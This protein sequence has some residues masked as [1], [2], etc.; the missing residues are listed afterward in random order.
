M[1]DYD[2]HGDLDIYLANFGSANR[3]FRNNGDSTF[4]DIGSSAGVADTGDGAGVAFGDYD[5]D[6]DLDLYLAN[7]GQANALF[8]NALNPY[9]NTFFAVKALSATNKWTQSGVR[10][11]LKTTI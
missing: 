3:L 2:A 8:V 10:V 6:G 7:Y 5:A 4:T 1:G 9:A 11:V